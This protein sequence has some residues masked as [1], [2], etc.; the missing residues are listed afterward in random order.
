MGYNKDTKQLWFFNETEFKIKDKS[1]NLITKNTY[2]AS[3]FDQYGRLDI[4]KNFGGHIAFKDMIG[5]HAYDLDAFY[6]AIGDLKI[7]EIGLTGKE[8]KKF[9]SDNNL[10]ANHYWYKGNRG[11]Q[12]GNRKNH[13]NLGHKGLNNDIFTGNEAKVYKYKRKQINKLKKI[14]DTI[15]KKRGR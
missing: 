2:E 1:G 12:V 7:K 9:F 14:K 5:V 11:Y 4:K 6:D 8:V 15:K 10:T 13:K 3:R